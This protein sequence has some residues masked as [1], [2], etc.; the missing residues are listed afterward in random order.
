MNVLIVLNIVSSIGVA[1]FGFNSLI[2]TYLFLRYA[3][4]S[5]DAPS[6]PEKW[7]T[8]VVQVPVFNERDVIRRGID[9]IASLDYPA[10]CLTLQILDDSDDDTTAIA[11][12]QVEYYRK[13]GVDIHLVRRADR[14]GYKAGALQ[15]GLTLAD[16]EFVAVFDADSLPRPDF[17]RRVI[18][19]MLHDPSLGIIQTRWSFVNGHYSLLTKLQG[20]ALDAHFIVEQTA[21]NRS[22]LLMHFNGTAGVLRRTCIEDS[23]GWESDTLSE[24]M[25]LSFRAQLA[26]WRCLHLPDIDVPTELP[27]TI[28][29]LKLQQ[30]RWSAGTIQCLRKL[31]ER[32]LRSD[33]SIWQKM[34][35]FLQLT[36]YLVHPLM[37]IILLIS[38]PS[39]FVYGSRDL[40]LAPLTLAAFGPPLMIFVAQTRLFPKELKKLVYFPLLLLFGFGIA[41]NNTWGVVDGFIGSQIAFRRTPKFNLI[42][43]SDGWASSSYNLS[44]DFTTWLEL[45]LAVY[46]LVGFILAVNQGSGLALLLGVYAVGFGYV[47][48]MSLLQTVQWKLSATSKRRATA[49]D[50]AITDLSSR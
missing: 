38:V 33:L 35:A 21:R 9:A 8:V 6:A 26:G 31:G 45:F 43:L 27:P 32:L 39:L 30:R 16:A 36:G 47:A 48:G 18:P 37:L 41:V 24:D 13:L 34:Q 1:L 19:H 5:N 2:L 11:Q 40:S 7:P 29:S 44:I 17:L 42:D 23:G 20:L 15:Y 4:R 10:D 46:S 28:A 12:K 14:T 25:D 49:I 3:K 22:G 50:A